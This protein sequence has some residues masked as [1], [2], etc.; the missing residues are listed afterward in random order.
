VDAICTLLQ[1]YLLV[2]FVRILM[3][4][5]PIA[6]GGGAERVY[7]VL[8]GLTEPILGPLRRTIPPVRLGMSALD[9]S[10][11]IVLIGGNILIANLC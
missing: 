10:P 8:Y 5:F 6:P 9:L 3:S 1:L 11:L 2:V 7:G 4:W